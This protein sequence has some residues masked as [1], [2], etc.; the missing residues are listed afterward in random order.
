YGLKDSKVR[1]RYEN[2]EGRTR[3]YDAPYEGVVNNLQRRFR[4]SDSDYQRMEIERYMANRP[5][6]VCQG[7]RLKPESLAVT[8]GERA[9]VQVTRMSVREAADWFRQLSDGLTDREMTIARQVL[10]EIRSRLGFLVDV[11]LDY[12]TLD[13]AAGSLSGG[14]AQRIRLA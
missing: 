13:R 6:V 8:V 2:R 4:E 12:L 9:I 3:E 14:E 11:G 7:M 1:L 10:K 5:C